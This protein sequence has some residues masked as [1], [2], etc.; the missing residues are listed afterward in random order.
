VEL[1]PN[2]DYHFV[3]NHRSRTKTYKDKE[4]I[5]INSSEDSIYST[6]VHGGTKQ[7]VHVGHQNTVEGSAQRGVQT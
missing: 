7:T 4:K 5:N 1:C 6:K 3:I 2:L